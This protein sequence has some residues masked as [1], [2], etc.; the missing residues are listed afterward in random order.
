MAE[1]KYH[2]VTAEKILIFKIIITVLK[3]KRPLKLIVLSGIFHINSY[4]NTLF[5]HRRTVF[6]VVTNHLQQKISFSA[7]VF[8]YSF[9][10]R[11]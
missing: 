7:V 11:S 6:S 1:A 3:Q 2:P 5:L 4:V 10:H 8:E 9:V